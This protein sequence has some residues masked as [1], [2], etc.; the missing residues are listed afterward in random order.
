MRTILCAA[1][2]VFL[3]SPLSADE[4]RLK[5]GD[6]YSGTVVQL[7]GGTLTFKTAHGTL[8]IPWADV[9]A[10]TVD[11]TI[12]LTTAD[13]V[14]VSRAGG[15]IDV[16][17]TTALRRPEPPMSISGGAAA[18]FVKTGGNTEVN[19]IRVDADAVMRLR[20]NRYTLGA[21]LN[22]AKT[23]GVETARNWTGSARYDR[24]V[25]ERLFLNANAILTNDPFRDLDLRTALGA[26]IG[27][28]FLD[29]PVLKFSVDGGGAY[30]NENFDTAADD[31]YGAVRE[32]AK[33]DVLLASERVTLFHRHDGY[34]GVTGDDNLFVNTQNG[35]RLALAAGF[36]T[37]VQLDT[38][39]DRSPAPG[40]RSSDR[41]WALTL[42][43]RF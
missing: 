43:Y 20:E 21:A 3:A 14:E 16:I 11:E 36:V 2:L 33:L 41:T 30:V 19:S 25:S 8:D 22:R 35:V 39:Y 17:G 7:A 37:S 6:R 29:T 9:D 24:F 12:L 32:G 15:V 4:L 40:R 10:L 1:L 34:F 13:G 38:E 26:G 42:G 18:G 5:N 28:Q 27:Y 31:S 23:A